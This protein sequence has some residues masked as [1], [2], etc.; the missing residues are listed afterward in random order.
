MTQRKLR[1]AIKEQWMHHALPDQVAICVV[2][3]FK[4]K[5]SVNWTKKR[6]YVLQITGKRQVM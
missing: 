2:S 1:A 6:V 3:D 4:A 5:L